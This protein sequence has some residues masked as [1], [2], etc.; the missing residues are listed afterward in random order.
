MMGEF[1]VKLREHYLVWSTIIDAPITN[2]GT[3]EELK[4]WIRE[5][6]GT[7]GMEQLPERLARVEAKGT[8]SHRD[9][10]AESAIWLNRAGPNE[11][12]LT[13]EGIYRHYCLDEPVKNEWIVPGRVMGGEDDDGLTYEAVTAG[14]HPEG[15]RKQHAGDDARPKGTR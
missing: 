3:L 5:E 7:R 2:G 9:N 12:T 14:W 10:S 11:S 8:S 4:A 6:Y 15:S 13:I 1:I